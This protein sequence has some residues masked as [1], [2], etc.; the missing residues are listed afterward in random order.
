[1]WYFFVREWLIAHTLFENLSLLRAQKLINYEFCNRS[2]YYIH[3][4]HK[5]GIEWY[6]HF[7]GRLWQWYEQS[8]ICLFF[9]VLVNYS[10]HI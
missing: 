4:E 10:E 5:K 8:Y 1:M 6:V 2:D 9:M 3:K 7:I